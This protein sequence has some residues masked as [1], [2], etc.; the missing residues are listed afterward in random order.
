MT[1]NDELATALLVVTFI[2]V[3]LPLMYLCILEEIQSLPAAPEKKE[4]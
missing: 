2:F 3:L 1:Y 4:E